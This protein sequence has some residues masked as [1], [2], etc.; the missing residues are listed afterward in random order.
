MVNWLIGR[1]Q[2]RL[3]EVAAKRA[4]GGGWP[5]ALS[6]MSKNNRELDLALAE[7]FSKLPGSWSIE[8]N[9]YVFT[10]LQTTIQEDFLDDLDI[11]F[12]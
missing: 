8:I 4:A 3:A 11:E 5:H 2:A 12:S 10:I 1:S 6:V 9:E 7:W